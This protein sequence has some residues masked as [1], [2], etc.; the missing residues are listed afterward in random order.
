MLEYL[1]A[2]DDETTE[3][4][5]LDCPSC[6]LALPVVEE[7]ETVLEPEPEGLPE[8]CDHSQLADDNLGEGTICIESSQE[9]PL[10]KPD[11]T[12]LSSSPC[13]Y[14]YQGKEP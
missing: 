2:F 13:Y 6:P 8:A 14:F 5:P 4:C 12:H 1:S 3:V 9:E 10:N 11:T 7:E